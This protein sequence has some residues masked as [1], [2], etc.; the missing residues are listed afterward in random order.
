MQS[1]Y[2]WL[3]LEFFSMTVRARTYIYIAH[4][5]NITMKR[6]DSGAQFYGKEV[7]FVAN[8][9]VMELWNA[10]G[11]AYS[12]LFFLSLCSLS[13]WSVCVH[14]ILSFILFFWHPCSFLFCP[15]FNLFLSFLFLFATLI[16]SLL[17]FSSSV[18][19]LNYVFPLAHLPCTIQHFTSVERMWGKA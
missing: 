8:P 6:S 9:I 1:V 15:C 13:S 3:T 12:L 2:A 14:R 11:P 18:P 19:S 17:C 10:Q 7:N 5:Y 4:I 16:L